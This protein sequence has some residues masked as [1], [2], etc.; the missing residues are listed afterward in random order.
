MRKLQ[1][2]ALV[3][4]LFA[5][6]FFAGVSDSAQD[7]TAAI[8]GTVSDPSGAPVVGATVTA[9]DTERGTNWTSQT[10]AD[11]VY[12]LI[13]IP[14]GTY[15][16]KVEA[17]GFQSSAF[18]A[19]TLV[20]NQTA[21][22]DAQMKMGSMNETVEVSG[23]TPLLQ[24]QS[25]ELST[26]IDA[27]T[28]TTLPLAARNY[29]QLA[30]LSP[31]TTTVNPSS[32]SQ[33]Q[34]MTGAGRPD[35]NGNREQAVAFL[36]DGI[37]NM[38]AKNNEVAYMPNVDAIEEFNIITQNPSAD[39]GNFAGGIIS[40]SIKSGT[41]AFHGDAFEFLRNDFM[42][43]NTKTS[44]WATGVVQPKP[45]LRY[46]MFGGTGGGP[47]LKNKLFFFG[48]YQGMRIPSGGTSQAQLLTANERNGDFGQLCTQLPAASGPG[49]FN[50]SG[51]C[52]NPAGQLVDPN[53]GNAPIPFNLMSNSTLTESPVAKALFADTKHYPLPMTDTAYG[54]NYNFGTGKNFNAD[55]GDL[56]VDYKASDNDSVSFRYSK[57][58]VSQ[59]I[60]SALPFANAGAAE[61]TDEPGW[62]ASVSWTHSLSTNLVNEARF[63]AN[64]FRFNQNQT[65]TTG[66]GNISQA[67]G[68]NGANAQAPGLV[69]ITIPTGPG[70]NANLGLLNLWQIFHD[71]EIQ[72]ED[73]V[74]YTRGRHTLKTGFQIIRE[75]NNYVYPGNDGVLGNINISTL[76]GVNGTSLNR[77]GT[78]GACGSGCETGVADFWA[79]I[80]AG[81]GFRDSGSATLEHLRGSVIAGFF[82][83]DWKLKPTITLNLGVRF[84]DHTPFYEDNNRVVNFGL[85]DGSIQTV[86][87]GAGGYSARAL[88]NNYTGL[89]DWNPRI[90]IA[91]SPRIWGGK[92]VVRAAYGSSNYVEG[93]GSNEEL[94]LNLPYGN[95]ESTYPTGI[96]SL[97]GAFSGAPPCPA[98][99][100]SC[101]A[102]SR[103]RIFDQNFRPALIQQ[104]NFMIE[105]Q[106]ANSLT[107]QIGYVGQKGTH[108][109]NFEDVAQREGLN[110]QGTLAL[111]G[112]QI[113]A[114]AAGPF[115]GGL[116]GPC[117]FNPK[118]G[119][120]TVGGTP[121]APTITYA[122]IW[123]CGTPGSL[124]NAD[125]GGNGVTAF[126]ALAGANM[127]NSNQRYDALQAVLKERNYHGLSGQLAYTFSKCLS[128]SPGYFGT[129]WGSTQAQSSG[130]QPGW[131]NI[132]DPQ[133]NWGPCYYDETHIISSYLS[134][135]LPVG[136]GKQ[137]GRDASPV[138]D[139]IIG[140]WQIS[141][142]IGLHSGNA[143]T[144]NDF[145]G[146]A[147]YGDHSGTNSVGPY[148]LANLPNCSG[149]IGID[150]KFV[151]FSAGV[152][153]HIQWFDTS[154]ISVVPNPNINTTYSFAGGVVGAPIG[155]V[156]TGGGSFG[157]CSVGNI[158]G[159][160]TKNVDMTLQKEIHISEH[161]TLQ[162]RLDAFNLFNHPIWTFSGGPASGSFDSG[163]ASLGQITGSQGERQL[164][165]ALKFLF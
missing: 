55:Q 73:N 100:F 110:A 70:G 94:S 76:T 161:K 18:P 138:V 23:E 14:V 88:Y 123:N 42:N 122:G 74:T 28:V 77:P 102:G 35:I 101:Y 24:T 83:D 120:S 107:F 10:N 109:L 57:F 154:N 75:R 30:L 63:G 49:A 127:S 155:S 145:G 11:G 9:H 71:T 114:E 119:S 159:P 22:L 25:T 160:W 54:A 141:S 56:K 85:T 139:A 5:A 164:Q 130:G 66:L 51:I 4:S 90:G 13:R 91:W 43:S 129:G 53:N 118:G 148:T 32:L 96:G 6:L 60:T 87:P 136:R 79:G 142:I 125:S 126:G 95:F 134:Y 17:K 47:I 153:A 97:G 58:D 61:G 104:W 99:Q 31:G 1:F 52:S 152:P 65:P 15:T 44:S 26:I 146:W 72:G 33:P 144:L 59:G 158:R 131:Q 7:V 40:V 50:A 67:L 34:L 19:F 124:Y 39:F 149:P 132:Y 151:P 36:L 165:I 69:Q 137:F 157:T 62:S 48:D 113:V 117:T 108:L 29:V 162:L 78:V 2:F 82:Q 116:G 128:N 163:S 111:P 147:A 103:I 38:E 135:Q 115:L 84:E 150:N 121:A 68:I 21:R 41:N 16:L 8:T 20:L 81:G 37:V 93:G 3:F 156:A 80:T 106:F 46:N 89:G 64:V 105:Q 112:Q 27:N 98:P 86:Q 143:L 92:T 45:T 12:S 140:N 133:A